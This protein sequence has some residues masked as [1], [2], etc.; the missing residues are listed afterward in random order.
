MNFQAIL[1]DM[2]GVIV[3]SEPL[4][5]AAF[6]SALKRYG[7]NLTHDHYKR[8]F[9]GKT[10]ETGFKLYFDF[11]GETV[12][13]PVIMDEKAKAYL[14][15]AADQLN[16]Y[17][18]VI[19]CIHDLTKRQVPLALVT[20]SLRVEVDVTLKTFQLIDD[21]KVVVTAED[22]TQSKPSPEGYLKGAKTLG[23][24][25]SECLVIEDSQSGVQAARN[26]KMRCV[27]LTTTHTKE[28]LVGAGATSI[29]TQLSPGCLDEL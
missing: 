4:H 13:I 21:F 27:A 2:D 9:A 18:G 23:I 10:D 26:A 17:P 1:F 14:E 3:D 6:Q 12:S 5:V 20:G 25:P 22:V 8:Y 15:L 29:L 28:E 19:E 16:P 11:V 24:A 7:H